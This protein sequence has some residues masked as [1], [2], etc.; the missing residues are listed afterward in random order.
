MG[1]VWELYHS[2]EHGSFESE[3]WRPHG[4]QLPTLGLRIMDGIRAA[5]FDEIE[6]TEKAITN[7]GFAV[8][9]E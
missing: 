2:V 5:V 4:G 1:D 9:Q 3:R 8:P 7:L 6:A